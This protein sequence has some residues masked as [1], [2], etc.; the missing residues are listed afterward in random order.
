MT[1]LVRV[2]GVRRPIAVSGTRD[3]RIAAIADLQRGRVSREQLLAAGVADRT[4]YGRVAAGH[5][6][7]E[8]RGVYAVG[9]TAP[10]PLAAE[11]S[12]LL[13]CGQH[14]VLSH[15]T[16]ALIHGLIPHGNGRI[17]VTIRG[18]HGA[19]PAGT[20]VHRTGR[21]N[22]S[23]VETVDLLP[24]TSPLR[25]I[26]DLA[27]TADVATT[28]RVLEE[29][30][31]QR[32]VSERRLRARAAETRGQ[33]SRTLVT[34]ILDAHSEP[35]ITKSEAERRFRGLLRAAQLPQPKTNFPF[36]G[37]SLDCYWPELGVVVEIQ[38]YKFHSSRKKF[39]HDTRKAAKLA[40]AGLSVSYVTWLQ[41][42]NEPFAVVARTAQTLAA[43]AA[44]RRDT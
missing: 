5:L 33:R 19:T 14:A 25:T 44:V 8:H 6:H 34:A 2:L 18:R 12:A 35:G 24:V 29:A 7:R 22:R 27:R 4:I 23:E 37:Y 9:H 42:D 28:E 36:H 20:T 17:H 41:M 38:G 21:L 43:A 31:T 11:T 32:K 10:A 30:L 16:A 15:H 39:E 13:A 3:D 1:N 26:F 40:A